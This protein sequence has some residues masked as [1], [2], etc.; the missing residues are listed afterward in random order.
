[1]KVMLKPQIGFRAVF[2]RILCFATMANEIPG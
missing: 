1:M 2:N